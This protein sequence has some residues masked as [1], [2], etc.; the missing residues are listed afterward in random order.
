MNYNRSLS[1]NLFNIYTAADSAHLLSATRIT[2]TIT[3][4]Y[5]EAWTDIIPIINNVYTW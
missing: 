2:F 1:V 5:Y 3:L 4:L